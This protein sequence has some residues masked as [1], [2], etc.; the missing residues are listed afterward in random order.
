MS[1][2]LRPRLGHPRPAAHLDRPVVHRRRRWSSSRLEWLVT[3][4]ARAG[5]ASTPTARS[6]A[7]SVG[8]D[9]DRQHARQHDAAR[10]SAAWR[11]V[12][13]QGRPVQHRRAGPV[14]DGR[15]RLRSS[16]A[17]SSRTARRSSPFPSRWS[18]GMLVGA[19]WGFIP[20]ILKAVSGAHEVVTTIMLNFVAIAILAAAVSGPLERRRL[21]VADHRC[22]RQRGPAGHHRRQR[23]DLR[24]IYA[25]IMAVLVRL[26]AVPD[27]ARVRDPD[28]RR[29][30]GRRPLRRHAPKRL[31][32]WTM[33]VSGLLAGMAGA[34][35]LLGVT[36]QMT[37]SYGTTVGFD[38]IAVALLGRTSPI[39]I[40]LAALLFGAL[41]TGARRCRSRPAC[42]PSWSASSRRRS[43]SSWSSAPSSSG[44]SGCSGAATG[45]EDDDDVHRAPTAAR[46]RSADGPVPVRPSRS[47]VSSSSS[48]T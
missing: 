36:H 31:I 33:S 18:P 23:H 20:G 21:A 47:S 29:E 2:R 7:G 15:A 26:A 19:A 39:G 24:I 46:P 28:R 35:D 11:S 25:P 10:C 16:S 12:W 4:D 5:P 38:A 48:A 6:I 41:R 17:S 42:R 27:D 34:T 37:T 32:I 1:E 45:L 30:P 13:L 8:S 9:R 44:S 43:C 40:V 3:G 14:P 22:R